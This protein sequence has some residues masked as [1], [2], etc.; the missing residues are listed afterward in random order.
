MSRFA[1]VTP[2]EATWCGHASLPR[3]RHDKAYAAL[4][5]RG[6][7][8][9]SGSR[10][11]HRVGS[12]QVLLHGRFDAHV[13]R[14]AAQGARILNLLLAWQPHCAVGEVADADA[15]ARLAETDAIAA[16][17]ALL[18]QLQPR[19]PRLID[20]P[21][22]LARDLLADTQLRLGPWSKRHGLAA[23]TLSRGFA[24]V[25][26]TSA[27]AFRAEARVHRAL[28][29]LERGA[30]PLTAVA[31]TCGFADQAHMTRAITALTGR[32][33]GHWLRSNSFKTGSR[34]RSYKGG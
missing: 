21:D 18:E 28:T 5:L 2:G 26:A 15:I 20:W 14:F 22:L 10:G 25:F 29:V 23:E 12:G 1:Q 31:A 13:D 4:V 8:E 7:Y 16:S 34:P 27:A 33:P 6:G 24:R 9:E 11:R 30:L 19:E 3:H 32:P 17:Q